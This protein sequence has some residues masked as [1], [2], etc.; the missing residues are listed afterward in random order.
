MWGGT[1]WTVEP[2]LAAG[3]WKGKCAEWGQGSAKVA[4]FQGLEGEPLP[5][6]FQWVLRQQRQSNGHKGQTQEMLDPS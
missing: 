2:A 4:P 6:W 5:S 1:L 3:T